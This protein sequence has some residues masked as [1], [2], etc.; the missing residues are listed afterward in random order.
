MGEP[1]T[2]GDYGHWKDAWAYSGPG[3]WEVMG[4]KLLTFI[5]GGFFPGIAI[6]EKGADFGAKK[7]DF[8]SW[9]ALLVQYNN[10]QP[11]DKEALWQNMIDV[12]DSSLRPEDAAVVKENLQNFKRFSDA[13]HNQD[14]A[15]IQTIEASSKLTAS[16]KLDAKR[17]YTAALTGDEQYDPTNKGAAIGRD[18][19][20]SYYEQRGFRFDDPGPDEIRSGVDKWGRQIDPDSVTPGIRN[21]RPVEPGAGG[22]QPQALGPYPLDPNTPMPVSAPAAAEGGPMAVSGTGTDD[23]WA[24]INNDID[25]GSA[26][27]AGG[28]PTAE[29]SSGPP[30]RVAPSNYV[31]PAASASSFYNYSTGS[32]IP[33]HL[34]G[35]WDALNNML[36]GPDGMRYQRYLV[37]DVAAKQKWTQEYLAKNKGYE[38]ELTQIG[39]KY[40]KPTYGIAIGGQKIGIVPK[41]NVMVMNALAG[42]VNQKA[43]INEGSL[44]AQNEAGGPNAASQQYMATLMKLL[45]SMPAYQ[46][47]QKEDKDADWLDYGN[48]FA[49]GVDLFGKYKNWWG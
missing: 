18:S 29:A 28:A 49:K 27:Q 9:E 37:Q 41:R 5:F 2:Y 1:D 16:Q 23:D 14:N 31:S 17:A 43:G 35:L 24:G 4:L 47:P 33:P 39:D 3:G 45:Q 46:H 15:A 11:G 6:L 12:V 32:Q 30:S 8:D 21:Q 34:Q 10:A 20:V 48:L 13:G 44:K 38:Q 42:L 26:Y 19:W 40:S 25:L 7:M 36:M 22:E